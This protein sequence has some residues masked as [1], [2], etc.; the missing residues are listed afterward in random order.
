MAIFVNLQHPGLK[1]AKKPLIELVQRILIQ[2]GKR[3]RIFD[4]A[5]G[6]PIDPSVESYL[7][8]PRP[9]HGCV[10]LFPGGHEPA[11]VGGYLHQL[12]R[13]T[14]PSVGVRS[15]LRL[16]GPFAS[17]TWCLASLRARRCHSG[18]TKG[19]GRPSVQI[20]DMIP[21]FLAFLLI[22]SAI[23]P[24]SETAFLSLGKERMPSAIPSRISK[25]VAQPLHFLSLILSGNTLANITFSPWQLRMYWRILGRYRAG[26]GYGGDDRLG[27]AFGEILPKT[28]GR[29]DPGEV[30]LFSLVPPSTCFL[31]LSSLLPW[32]HCLL[33]GEQK[34][35][36]LR[37]V[38]PPKN[39]AD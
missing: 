13:G 11:F 29:F 24:A 1:V 37:S 14:A 39:S 9:M 3:V 10:G 36:W 8:W 17:D 32:L 26:L 34:R 5:D 20:S 18:R 16:R 38:D 4:Y 31:D 22:C 12:G 23:F 15:F 35:E 7:P 25:M 19:D 30:R 2:E 27:V 28:I 33:G 21:A 6:G